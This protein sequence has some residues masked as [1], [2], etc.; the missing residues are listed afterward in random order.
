M[1]GQLACVQVG[2]S[3]RNVGTGRP[4][5]TRLTSESSKWLLSAAEK[6]K[7][8]SPIHTTTSLYIPHHGHDVVPLSYLF[9]IKELTACSIRH[10][11]AATTLR[12]PLHFIQIIQSRSG[13]SAFIGRMGVARDP[14]WSRPPQPLS[15]SLRR[16]THLRPPLYD[17]RPPT[18][19]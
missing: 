7:P 16:D 14:P 15:K 4:I 3:A 12:L 9:S 19:S 5:F 11:L 1:H 2:N 13:P 18:C 6:S 17:I 10:R 8:P